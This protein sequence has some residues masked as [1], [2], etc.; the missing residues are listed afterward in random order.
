MN[1]WIQSCLILMVFW[2][3]ELKV[4]FWKK[5]ELFQSEESSFGTSLVVQWLRICIAIHGYFALMLS[6]IP[7]LILTQMH[8]SWLSEGFI[9]NCMLFKKK[10]FEMLG[11][12]KLIKHF[13]QTKWTNNHLEALFTQ[14]KPR[15][16]GKD[17]WETEASLGWLPQCHSLGAT[18]RW[19]R[20]P[21]L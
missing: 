18:S 3:P 15:R 11:C 6:L 10:G 5:M 13:G 21:C 9:K 1:T 4:F 19:P 7:C 16:R 8:G 2:L 12:R 20:Q 14:R 17:D